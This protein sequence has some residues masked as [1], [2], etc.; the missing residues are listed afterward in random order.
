MENEQASTEILLRLLQGSGIVLR[1]EVDSA[2]TMS[3]N[4]DVPIIDAIKR[5]GMLSDS[6]LSLAISLKDK[7]VGRELTFDVAIR[8]LR[9]ALQKT[10]SVEEAIDSVNKLHQKTRIVVSATNELTNL[11]LTAKFLSSE[12]LGRMIKMSQDSSM[13]VGQ[14]LVIDNKISPLELISALNAVVAIREERLVSAKAT[15]A[16]RYARQKEIGFEQALFELAFLD[17]PEKP[18]LKVRDLFTMAGAISIEDLAESYEIEV[19][20]KKDFEQILL[21]RAL[22]NSYQIQCSASLM[23]LVEKEKLKPFQAASVLGKICVNEMKMDGALSTVV[24]EQAIEKRD[25]SVSDFLVKAE[26]CSLAELTMAFVNTTDSARDIIPK[27]TGARILDE[28]SLANALRAWAIYRNGYMATDDIIDILK[29][30]HQKQV[31]LDKV[32]TQLS[33]YIPACAQWNW[34]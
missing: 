16:L 5:T 2:R 22:L 17:V 1:E 23:S 20:K 34:L 6:N 28:T 11:L 14:L 27:V 7:I 15:Q 8:A 4:L 19:F 33:I 3:Q 29:H 24:P 31:Y 30:C 25:M 18:D 13:M 21:E 26:V 9:I 32:L 10:M 12:D